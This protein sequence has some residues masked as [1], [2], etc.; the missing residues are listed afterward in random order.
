MT[1][2]DPEMALAWWALVDRLVHHAEIVGI[3]GESYRQKEAQ[4]QAKA[5]AGKRK[6]S[7]GTA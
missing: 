1:T 4:E 3:K 7:K 5:R 6:T 2:T